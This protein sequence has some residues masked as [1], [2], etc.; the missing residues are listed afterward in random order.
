MAKIRTYQEHSLKVNDLKQLYS[1]KSKNKDYDK[2]FISC[3]DDKLIKIW[4][5]ELNYSLK[6]YTNNSAVY[7]I[8]N[9]SN[10]SV[11]EEYFMSGDKNKSI[12]IWKINLDKEDGNISKRN[13]KL[14]TI[15]TDH[16]N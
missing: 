4:N 14:I 10:Y 13:N 1:N 11:D 12:T 2:L 16:E 15:T 6:T 3:S 7:C 5:C 9:L 8:E